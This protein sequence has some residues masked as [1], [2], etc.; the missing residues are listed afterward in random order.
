[1]EYRIGALKKLKIKLTWDLIILLLDIYPKKKKTEV[2][3]SKNDQHLL[4][5]LKDYSK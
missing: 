2:K 5:P 3:I 1:M 4:C